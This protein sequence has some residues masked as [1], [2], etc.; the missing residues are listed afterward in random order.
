MT[1]NALPIDVLRECLAYDPS[2]GSF[3]WLPRPRRHFLTDRA[4]NISLTLRAGQPAFVNTNGVGYA[5]C[6]LRYQGDVYNLLAHRVAWGLCTGAWPA[7]TIDH[8]DGDR[9]NNR[10]ANLREATLSE[11]NRNRPPRGATGVKNV[12]QVNRRYRARGLGRT[13]LGYFDTVEA[14]HAAAKAFVIRNGDEFTRT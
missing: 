6:S 10:F 14:A 1:E 2:A 3:T 13:H 12:S 7:A 4:W 5:S 11:N 8:L 9:A